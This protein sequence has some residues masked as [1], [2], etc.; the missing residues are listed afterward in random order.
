MTQHFPIGI[1]SYALFWEFQEG[2]PAPLDIAGMIDRAA[3]LDCDVFQICDDPRI[4]E[5]DVDGL[6]ELRERAE[7]LGIALELGTRTIGR[8][9]LERHLRIAEALGAR[10]LRSMIQSQEI[11]DGADVATAELR[12]VLPRLEA[13]GVTLALETYE[14]VPT[15]TLLEVIEAVDSPRVGI[16]LDPANC[17]SALEH[18][19][20]V[21]DACARRTV[22]LHVKDFAFA[23]QAGW[24]GFTYSGARMGE[25]LHDY[26]HLLD[27]V[28]P[29]ERGINEVVEHWLPWQADAATTIRTERDWTRATLEYLRST[30]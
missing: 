23:R 30:L 4:E 14:Q 20:Q 19:K 26:R 21:V 16:C 24:V 25:G 27:V 11:A 8:D 5:L 28:M 1:G 2:N 6:R 18:P 12:A 13:A 3:Q 7:I 17:V 10:T 22:N 29:R 9:H 15:S